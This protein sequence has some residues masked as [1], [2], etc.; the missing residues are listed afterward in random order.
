[1]APRLISRHPLAS[2][3][4]SPGLMSARVDTAAAVSSLARSTQRYRRW[5]PWT[6]AR[7]QST[8]S[9]T[10]LL[11]MDVVF[12]WRQKSSLELTCLRE[13]MENDGKTLGHRV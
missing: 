3:L 6:R 13:T 12:K 1:M 8:E 7:R 5:P 11:W 2:K 10:Q 4:T 9:V